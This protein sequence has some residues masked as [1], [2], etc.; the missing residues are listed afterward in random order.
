M[1]LTAVFDAFQ[2]SEEWKRHQESTRKN[3]DSAIRR[4]LGQLV[5]IGTVDTD[6]L[7]KDAR[8]FLRRMTFKSFAPFNRMLNWAVEKELIE[9]NPVDRR[10]SGH[11]RGRSTMG[12]PARTRT[13]TRG[14]SRR[15]VRP[16][17]TRIQA[18]IEMPCPNCHESIKVTIG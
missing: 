10:K 4:C 12:P 3:Y 13:R 15:P 6:Q 9:A 2:E 14:R 17:I 18:T 1:L 5:T 11:R 16:H 7:D 8:D